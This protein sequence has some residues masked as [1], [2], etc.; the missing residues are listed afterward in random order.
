[1]AEEVTQ[2]S[3]TVTVKQERMKEEEEEDI[4][5]QIQR[6]MRSRV[7]HFQEQADSFTL[8]GVR[9][10][11]EKD[12]GLET[13]ALD[14]HKR[15]IRQCLSECLEGGDDDNAS[16]KSG[17]TVGE[18]VSSTKGK[19]AESHE[20]HL[21]KKNMEPSSDDEE[22]MEDSPVM[23]L[24]IGHKKTKLEA[25]ETQ[26]TEKKEVPSEVTIKKA[27]GK[28]ATYFSA[29]S[30]AINMAG[31]RRLL[32]E[33]LELDKKSLDPFKKF[34]SEQVEEVLE[35]LEAF[36]SAS[37]VK[38]RS[39]EKNSHSKVSKNISTKGS[40]DSVDS[41]SEVED[42]VKSKKKVAPK[43][44]IQKSEVLK[45]RKRPSNETKVSSKKPKKLAETTSE[46]NSD[47][48]DGGNVSEDGQSE[49]PD[50]KP[51]KKKEIS[52]P[53]YGKQ[54]ESLKS[55]IKSCGMSVP[56]SVYKRAKQAP[57]NK[58]EAFL[59]K[60][61]AEILSREGLSTNPSEKEIKEV[62]KRKERAKE[63]EGI[64]TSNIVS[65]SRRR[66]T[67]SFVTLPKPKPK[68]PVESDVDDAEDTD[69]DGEDDDDEGEDDDDDDDNDGNDSQS[70]EFNEDD[71]DDSD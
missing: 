49:S 35:S 27:I 1:M 21:T 65:S 54:V 59:I 63:L 20:N 19:V 6:A 36:E 26:G 31:V 64:D 38:K 53:A 24:L 15:F 71:D 55:I 8:E 29:N 56:P 7:R 32:E 44:K 23:G 57:E 41:E 52:A 37:N 66:S 50:E 68:V 43:G 13:Y 22:K 40:Y 10:L 58:R 17:E 47:A 30:H 12:L 62:R 45:K 46:E 3:S 28:R 18:N 9:R 67:S 4:E 42:E 33:D 61:L 51:V 2:D 60:E 25:K 69:N 14:V 16:K 70:E 11:L 39:T 34:I 48:E 5:F